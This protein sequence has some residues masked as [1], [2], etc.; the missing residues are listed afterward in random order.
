MNDTPKRPTVRMQP[1]R[2]KRVA[3]G[4]PWAYSN[5]IQMDATTKAVPPGSVVRLVTH[6]GA[7]L[8]CATFN[9]HTLIAARVLDQDPDAT[10]DRAFLAG[11]LARAAALRERVVG[12]PFHRLVHAEADGLPALVVDRFGD[13]VVVQ[14]NSAG[15]DR[16]LPELLGALDDVLDPRAVVLRHDTPARGL[17]GLPSE[18][19]VAKGEVEGPVAVEE[20]GLAFFADPAGGQKTGW[21]YDQRDNRAFVAG[22]AAGAR[23]LDVYSYNGGFA[24]TCAARGAASVVAVD[25]SEGALD[26]GRRAAEANGVAGRCEFRKA[27]AF[28]E[29]ERMVEAGE[30]F[31][32]VISDP[33]AFVKS[34]KDLAAGARGYRK[35]ARLSAAVTAPGGFLLLA[36][37]SHHMNPELFGEQVAAGL[38]DARRTGRILRMAGAA[39]DHPVHPQLPESA[40]LKAWVLQVD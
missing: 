10:V 31:D 5:E 18:V 7:P 36:S 28:V 12:R 19:R 29:L 2:H 22:L 4:H 15:M 6:N 39:P 37:C 40:Y 3:H 14:A 32:V 1:S 30:R 33:P 34:K 17:E 24:V 16:L 23:V 13:V 38:A 20:N 35:L 27:D 26:N 25:R 11:R 9:P 21:F 8:G